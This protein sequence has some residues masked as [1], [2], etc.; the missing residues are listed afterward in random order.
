ML[1]CTDCGENGGKA[2]RNAIVY[3]ENMC[4]QHT[5]D[6]SSAVGN[7]VYYI[8]RALFLFIECC[9]IRTEKNRKRKKNPG[10][11]NKTK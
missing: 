1:Y 11:K 3:D 9:C 6:E 4:H 10:E 7:K 5:G 8:L 2:G